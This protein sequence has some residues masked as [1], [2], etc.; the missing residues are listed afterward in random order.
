MVSH[1][2]NPAKSADTSAHVVKHLG[3][4]SLR[5][6]RLKNHYCALLWQIAATLCLRC[7]KVEISIYA[8]RP[9]APAA[10]YG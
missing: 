4:F 3:M 5:V 2:M 10:R 7:L 1:V 8:P 9:M 6:G